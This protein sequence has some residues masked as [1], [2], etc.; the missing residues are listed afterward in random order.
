MGQQTDEL[1]D[2][3]SITELIGRYGYHYDE[4]RFEEWLAD[5]FTP[6]VVCTRRVNGEPNEYVF[7]GYDEVRN[8]LRPRLDSFRERGIQRRHIQSC[9]WIDDL[10]PDRAHAHSVCEIL[11]TPTGGPTA[12][13]A[14]GH[15][16]FDLVKRNGRWWISA[17]LLSLD[18][19]AV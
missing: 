13:A 5:L 1:A 10:G 3:F 17:W 14:C 2:R 15:Y 4:F 9:I 18:A 8:G 6:D 19:V 11:S 7:R 12:I 16:Q